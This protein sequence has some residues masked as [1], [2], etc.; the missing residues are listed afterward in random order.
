MKGV[1]CDE[2]APVAERGEGRA[3]ARLMAR[4][5]T[6]YFS[7]PERDTLLC[8]NIP[9]RVKKSIQ[10]DLEK[11]EEL[12]DSKVDRGLILSSGL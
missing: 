6:G 1:W 8:V 12:L 7:N 10:A 5:W 3:I 11:G 9:R 4:F 2:S